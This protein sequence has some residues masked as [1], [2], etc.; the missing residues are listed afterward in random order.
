MID[1]LIKLQEFAQ[2]IQKKSNIN[3][4]SNENRTKQYKIVLKI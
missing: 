2:K 4:H 1:S 3:S